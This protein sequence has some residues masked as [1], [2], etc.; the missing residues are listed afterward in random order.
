M[1]SLET[2]LAETKAI[3]E[4]ATPGPWESINGGI[5]DS[6]VDVGGN[7]CSICPETPEAKANE[8]FILHAR[9][10]MPALMEALEL[11]VEQRNDELAALDFIRRRHTVLADIY[12]DDLDQALADKLRGKAG[13]RV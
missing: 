6:N 12:R 11:A 9:T 10:M 7:V 13:D 8:E 3:V 5:C 4:A 1:K 2:L